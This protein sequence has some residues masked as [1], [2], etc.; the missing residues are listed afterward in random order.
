MLFRFTGGHLPPRGTDW[1]AVADGVRLNV[2]KILGVIHTGYRKNGQDVMAE[3]T[4][5][6]LSATLPRDDDG[7]Y[8]HD[9]QREGDYDDWH[10][11]GS[12]NIDVHDDLDH[13]LDKAKATL[14]TI[15][16]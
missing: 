3:I 6:E 5:A 13:D 15:P 4:P 9:L 14:S 11:P 12:D 8:V 7:T 16:P 10:V 2:S 1:R